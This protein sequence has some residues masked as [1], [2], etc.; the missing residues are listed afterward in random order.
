MV[1]SLDLCP[2]FSWQY[3]GHNTQQDVRLLLSPIKAT[4]CD[5]WEDL[6]EPV[7]SFLTSPAAAH[8]RDPSQ[9]V[10]LASLPYFIKQIP[11]V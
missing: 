4:P 9:R 11:T 1:W 3:V 8:Q 5:G 7:C 6:L 10:T 2:L